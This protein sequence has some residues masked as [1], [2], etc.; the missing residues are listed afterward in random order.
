M[1]VTILPVVASTSPCILKSI[2]S[3]NCQRFLVALLNNCALLIVGL[4]SWVGSE[5][6]VAKRP[7]LASSNASV[8]ANGYVELYLNAFST[9]E[10]SPSFHTPS[11]PICVDVATF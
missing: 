10:P 4:S 1:L 6:I 11:I 3:K 2:V 8:I 9:G 5:N 7:G